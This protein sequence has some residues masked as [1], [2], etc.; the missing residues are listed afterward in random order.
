MRGAPA[1]CLFALLGCGR[2]AYDPIAIDAGTAVVADAN[3]RD[4]SG[5]DGS[6]PDTSDPDTADADTSLLPVDAGDA[7]ADQAL[8]G[9]D[10]AA[11]PDLGAGDA[12]ACP[13]G[14]FFTPV[15][16]E[17]EGPDEDFD[18][19]GPRLGLDGSALYFSQTR[20]LPFRDEDLYASVRDNA[21][22]WKFG[23]PMRLSDLSS[24]SFDGSPFPTS[25]SLEIF[26]S[27]ARPMGAGR[28]DIWRSSR[29]L[30]ALTWREPA[31]VSEL[32]S[33][34]DDQNPSLTTDALTIFF[35][36]DRVSQVPSSAGREDIFT[37]SRPSR[38]AP[39]GPVSRVSELSTSQQEG[40]PAISGDGLTIFFTSNRPGGR[41]R[42]DIWTANRPSRSAPFGTAVPLV[43]VNSS[44]DD[45]DAY[46]SSSGR[47]LFLS[48]DRDGKS[49]R[50]Y[51]A[52]KCP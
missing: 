49:R 4:T 20:R 19:A 23:R 44:E 28:R 40:A 29:N 45:D 18:Q 48:S 36:S 31:L 42:M 38:F 47:E 26:F 13:S 34:S 3:H 37:A 5:D 25:D 9:P 41:G 30:P 8:P 7:T 43:E 1:L 6:F 16:I 22:P 52:I 11:P 33:D 15:A 27:S 32:S 24:S 14:K 51:R 2:I 12:T 35:S 10:L 21:T 50:I 46:L 17:I 39:F